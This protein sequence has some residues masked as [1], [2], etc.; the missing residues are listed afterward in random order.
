MSGEVPSGTN[1]KAGDTVVL[2]GT[3]H[4]FAGSVSYIKQ[5]SGASFITVYVQL[6]ANVFTLRFVQVQ[7]P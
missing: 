5:E 6:P 3:L 2:P 7:M 1:I 4:A